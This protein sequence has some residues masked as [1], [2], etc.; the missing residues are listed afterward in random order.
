MELICLNLSIRLGSYWLDASS[1]FN[2][3]SMACPVDADIK[4]WL[5]DIAVLTGT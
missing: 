1:L 3:S 2:I 4:A 5:V